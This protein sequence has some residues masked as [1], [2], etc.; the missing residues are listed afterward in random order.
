MTVRKYADAGSMEPEGVSPMRC[1]TCGRSNAEDASFCSACG[2]RLGLVCSRC[3]T[4][5]QAGDAFCSSCGTR[6]DAAEG[7]SREDDLRRYVPAELLEKLDTARRRRAMAGERRMVTML[8]A[9]IQ[10]STAAAEQLDPEEWADIVNGAFERLIRPVY[11][12]EGTLARLMGDGVLAFFGAPIAHEDD[13]ERAIRA[14]LAM[15]QEIAPYAREIEKRWSVSFDLRV[16]INTGLVVVGEVG[17]D[18][19]VEYTALGDAVNVAARMEQVAAP[20]TLL[21]SADTQRLVEPLFEFEPLEPVTVKGKT[22]PVACFR[23][24]GARDGWTSTRGLAGR[25][26]SLVGRET[27]LA[28][29]HEVADAVRGGRGQIAAV[30]G[31]AGVGKSRLTEALRA[32]LAAIDCVVAWS[33]DARRDQVRWA[34]ARCLSYNTSVAYA[35]FADLFTKAFGIE[36]DHD[37]TLARERVFAA[38]DMS[39]VDDPSR[40]G[41]YLCVLLGLDPGGAESGVVA[42]LPTPA[43]QRRVFSAVVDYL[44]ACSGS[45]PVLLVFEDL[46]WADSV[47][48]AL[49]EELLRATDRSTLGVIALMR[50]YRDDASWHF[51]ETA[52]RSFAHRYTP[53]HLEPLDGDA[54]RTLLHEL[55]DDGLSPDLEEVVLSR[56]EGNP[57]FVEEIVR[58]LLESG[59]SDTE[60]PSIPS[61]VSALL[62]SRIDRLESASKLVVQ[63]A[64]VFGREFEFDELAALVGDIDD[65]EHAL[66]DLLSRDLIVERSRIPDREYSFRH[67]LIQ[68]TAYSTVLL[69]DRRS[70]HAQV[71]DYL[72][73]RRFD[74]QEMA[75][76]LIESQQ[77]VK[78][79]PHLLEAAEQAARAMNLQQA[80]RLY[81]QVLT[82]VPTDESEIAVR[83]LDGLG[84]A[85]AL[86]PDLS[87]AAAAYQEMLEEGRK[88]AEP[89]VQVTALNRLGATTAFLSGD[90]E[91][92]N[93]YLEQARQL[94]EEV[95]DEMGLAQYHMN[96]CMIAT[97]L[98]DFDG[99][100]SH[101]AETARLGSAVG[102]EQVRIGGLVQRAQSLVYG[103]H[104][105]EGREALEHARRAAEGSNDPTVESNL[106]AAGLIL[107][108]REGDLS[109]AWTLARRAA[110]LASG[111]GSPTAAVLGIYAGMVADQMGS[112]EDALTY[113]AESLRLGEEL[114]QGFITAA[115]AASMVRIYGDLGIEDSTV[116][117]LQ[118]T[119]VDYL[120]RPMGTLLASVVHAELGWTALGRGEL[121]EADEWFRA[122]VEG[123]SAAKS[124]ETVSLLTGLALT[125]VAAGELD[126][127]SSLID[128]ASRYVEEKRMAYLRPHV[129]EA[130]GAVELASGNAENAARILDEGARL[131]ETMGAA[132]VAWRLRAA[133][134]GALRATGR[135]DEAEREE[136]AARS[137]IDEM[138]RRF[139]DSEMRD[140]FVTASRTRL[141]TLSGVR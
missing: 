10:G 100:A 135:V 88:R 36:P 53:I 120:A 34:E 103:G 8:F 42:D 104:F 37:D 129:A 105:D 98:G 54:A 102:S 95:G 16:G 21:V 81:D 41:T 112:L 26:T 13:P 141:A 50:P 75:R 122:G 38:A 76:H 27:E 84:S 5:Y 24:T 29:L 69:K 96:S 28:T 116:A 49:L 87:R 6:L 91:V 40:V 11:R 89:S 14:G 61:N 46:H 64:S 3:A 131:A 56:A 126:E 73:G 85:Y 22:E 130:R 66:S 127:A 74:P 44:Q 124:L 136:E 72:S 118:A 2:T 51:H 67:A 90:I 20:G 80:I 35:P 4:P 83:A 128:K 107:L 121:L 48:L 30:I 7:P 70:L 92:A 63:L 43:L 114:G 65:T 18:L 125:R 115:A 59:T 9:D 99:A 97:H 79:V 123:T 137:G 17:S 15:L 111:V 12:Y 47:S 32:S 58:S 78:A 57:F 134:A 132:H 62:T 86:I 31:E 25:S 19:R 71:A 133:R 140:S 138:A 33:D 117:S 108:M 45:I 119:A 39:G 82:W 1:G 94:A 77:E 113:Y 23:V 68:E 60:A 110:E 109:G 52:Q 101:D 93:G 106:A 55:I 139:V